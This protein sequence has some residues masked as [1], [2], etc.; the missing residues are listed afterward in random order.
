MLSSPQV[1]VAIWISLDFGAAG[2]HPIVVAVLAAQPVDQQP[3]EVSSAVVPRFLLF[4][5]PLKLLGQ[6]YGFHQ[7][8]PPMRGGR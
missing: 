1:D 2:F 3:V 8:F 4:P 6:P 7:H 5:P